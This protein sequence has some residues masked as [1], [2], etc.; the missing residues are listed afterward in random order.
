MDTFDE[1]EDKAQEYTR[2]L[3]PKISQDNP[4]FPSLDSNPQEDAP[5]VVNPTDPTNPSPLDSPA[6]AHYSSN[7]WHHQSQP[8]FSA[9]YDRITAFPTHL[10]STISNIVS[11][12]ASGSFQHQIWSFE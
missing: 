11:L 12:K 8:E 7:A 4:N 10:L 9:K 3:Y 1:N 2:L 6:V 5:L